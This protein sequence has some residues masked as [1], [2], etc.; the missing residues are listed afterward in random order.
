MTTFALGGRSPQVNHDSFIAPDAVVLGDVT[1][2]AGA[3]VWFGCVLRG[4]VEPIVIGDKTNIQDGTIIHTTEGMS[5]VVAERVVVGHGAVL[6]STNIGP[7]V[8]IGIR[9]SVLDGSIVGDGAFVAAGAVVAP[10]TVVPPG[11]VW[12]GVPARFLRMV[13]EDDMEMQRWAVEHYT[14]LGRQYQAD[15][16]A[17][18]HAPRHVAP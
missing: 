18:N 5:I 10:R 11:E 7:N 17:E 12:A 9:A 15:L 1:I 2:G 6:H 4:D 3:S 8:Q 16:V 14:Q 13:T